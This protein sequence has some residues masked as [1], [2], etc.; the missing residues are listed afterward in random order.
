MQK[1]N[2]LKDIDLLKCR[3]TRKREIQKTAENIGYS[4]VF[5]YINLKI[6][7]S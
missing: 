3:W 2:Y 1:K 5:V 7:L 6:I 4:S